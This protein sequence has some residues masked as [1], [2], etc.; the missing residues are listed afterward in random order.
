M[1]ESLTQRPEVRNFLRGVLVI[2]AGAFMILPAYLN[3]EIF[4]RLHFQLV[5]SMSISLMLFSIG[6]VTFILVLGKDAFEKK[7]ETQ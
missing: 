7:G 2:V 4:T 5:V 3:Y 1:V 6:I